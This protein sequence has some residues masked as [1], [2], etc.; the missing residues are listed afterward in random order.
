MDINLHKDKSIINLLE[1]LF[2]KFDNSNFS[3]A[4]FWDA[5]LF[6]IGIQDSQ[7][8]NYLIYISTYKK[9]NGRYFIEVEKAKEKETNNIS[10][11]EKFNDIN[12][13]QLT[14]IIEK[15]L[16]LETNYE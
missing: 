14:G 15:Y 11:V 3:I 6:A 4:D 7:S 13:E 9:L 8:K 5:D 12:F 1:K 10:V 2:T 16:V